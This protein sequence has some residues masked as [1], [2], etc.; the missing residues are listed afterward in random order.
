MTVKVLILG[1]STAVQIQLDT[2]CLKRLTVTVITERHKIQKVIII[3]FYDESFFHISF[4]LSLCHKSSH[5]CKRIFYSSSDL[6][7]C[8]VQDL[9]T[10]PGSPDGP[11][12]PG[13]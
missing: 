13:R 1:N 9:R 3:R 10:G 5:L 8:P 2:V 12:S 11:G 6:I 4:S 7:D